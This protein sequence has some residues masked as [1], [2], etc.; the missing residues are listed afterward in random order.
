MDARKIFSAAT[1][2]RGLGGLTED[3]WHQLRMA[4][5]RARLKIT[6]ERSGDGGSGKA[7]VKL[8]DLQLGRR[9]VRRCGRMKQ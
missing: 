9:R 2:S 3:L 5:Q 8:R 6:N 4:D 7:G 1:K